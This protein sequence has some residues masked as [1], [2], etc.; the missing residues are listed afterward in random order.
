MRPDVVLGTA[1]DQVGSPWLIPADQLED[2][3]P[4]PPLDEAVDPPPE[5]QP[6]EEPI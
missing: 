1:P 2:Q 3:N 5:E 4:D 6:G